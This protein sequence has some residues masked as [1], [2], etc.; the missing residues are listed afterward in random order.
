MAAVAV[1]RLYFDVKLSSACKSEKWDFVFV[2]V[3]QFCK[4]F[5]LVK[6][7]HSRLQERRFYRTTVRVLKNNVVIIMLVQKQI[8]IRAP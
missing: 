3:V 1:K 7:Y 8:L 4:V 2:F 6:T 5:L